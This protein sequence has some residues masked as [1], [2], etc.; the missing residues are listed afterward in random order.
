M[1]CV[2]ALKGRNRC[3]PT[4]IFR[5]EAEGVALVCLSYLNAANPAHMRYAVRRLRRKLPR[6]RIMVAL[7]SGLN[8]G[9]RD[10]TIIENAKADMLALTL[11]EAT[12]LSIE[13][14]RPA[15]VDSLDRLD[16]K[17]TTGAQDV[18]A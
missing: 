14:A 11:R 15:M 10:E 8:T 7:W 16:M 18:P 2:R 12:R 9:Q 6:A 4:I 5:L 1:D 17:A 13:A 3:P